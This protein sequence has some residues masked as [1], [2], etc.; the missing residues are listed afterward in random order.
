MLGL[1]RGSCSKYYSIPKNGVIRSSGTLGSFR[2]AWLYNPGDRTKHSHRREKLKSNIFSSYCPSNNAHTYMP[3]APQEACVLFLRTG[4]IHVIQDF[5]RNTLRHRLNTLLS[6][7]KE[8]WCCVLIDAVQP[9]W[10][11][12]GDSNERKSN[13]QRRGRVKAE[14][15]RV[16]ATMLAWFRTYQFELTEISTW[17]TR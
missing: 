1:R 5:W 7:A 9:G 16:W 6:S 10:R 8:M 11:F 17:P 3:I 2:T 4:G 15:R 12:K 14:W 13:L